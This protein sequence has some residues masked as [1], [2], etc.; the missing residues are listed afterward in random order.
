MIPSAFL[1]RRWRNA[2][3]PRPEA[4]EESLQ[5]VG[6]PDEVAVTK[7]SVVIE[8]AILQPGRER[9]Q[10]VVFAT[11]DTKTLI[12]RACIFSV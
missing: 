4:R 10:H 1:P 11:P 5:V 2:Y 9:S 3:E 12:R 6:R 7:R 8:L